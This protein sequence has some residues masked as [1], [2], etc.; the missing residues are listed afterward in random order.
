[1]M[2]HTWL[3]TC[4][5]VGAAAIVLAGCGGG[6]GGGANQPPANNAAEG[7]QGGTAT[8]NVETVYKQNCASCHGANLEGRAGPNSNLQKVGSRLS[9]DQI[10]AQI[11]N[12]GNGMMA[13]KG[14]LQDN[15]IGALADWLAAKK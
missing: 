9:K 6:A 4:A 8:V 5:A 11:A 10:A 15:E 2:K 12:G 14:K 7:A 3:R 13:F 1:M